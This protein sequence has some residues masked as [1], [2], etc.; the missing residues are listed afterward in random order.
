MPPEAPAPAL[1][2]RQLLVLRLA[3]EGFSRQEIASRLLLG[4]GTVDYHERVIIAALG[5]R[6]LRNAVHLAWMAGVLRRGRVLRDR[7]G[8][9]A[10]FRLH[11]RRGERPCDACVAGE[12]EYR[13][14]LRAGRTEAVSAPL[15]TELGPVAP[16]GREA[17]ES[18]SGVGVAAGS[19][20]A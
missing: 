9:H 12:R 13:R 3:A 19:S 16:E 18:P 2:D 7:H 11:E 1:S 14:G 10:G 4:E 20:A 5:A 8:D 6:N 17:A 15:S